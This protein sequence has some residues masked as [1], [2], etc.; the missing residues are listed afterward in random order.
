MIPA[1]KST[2]IKAKNSKFNSFSNN[3]HKIGKVGIPDCF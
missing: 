3:F 1:K 2:D